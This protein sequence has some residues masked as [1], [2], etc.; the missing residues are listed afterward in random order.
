MSK[1]SAQ[2][3][4]QFLRKGNLN[5][6]RAAKALLMMMKSFKDGGESNEDVF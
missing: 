1:E 3:A 6:L 4:A 5:V 2:A